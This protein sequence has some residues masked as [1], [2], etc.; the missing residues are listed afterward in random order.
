LISAGAWRRL[1]RSPDLLAGLKVGGATFTGKQSK[2]R[3]ENGE[4]EQWGRERREGVPPTEL[5]KP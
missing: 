4:R 2:R 5:L 3:G 1:Q